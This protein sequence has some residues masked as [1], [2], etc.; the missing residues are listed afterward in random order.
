MK[1]TRSASN[2]FH[3]TRGNVP[4]RE[5]VPEKLRDRYCRKCG[6]EYKWKQTKKPDVWLACCC[7][8]V[9]YEEVKP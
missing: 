4:Q 9:S 2:A 5:D 7:G 3:S 6:R 8:L 1:M